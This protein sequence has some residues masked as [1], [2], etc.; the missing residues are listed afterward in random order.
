MTMTKMQKIHGLQKVMTKID[1]VEVITLGL[2]S[3]FSKLMMSF[4]HKNSPVI[5]KQFWQ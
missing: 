2:K 5:R 4:D 1:T 3:V